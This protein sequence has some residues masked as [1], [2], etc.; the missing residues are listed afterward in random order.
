MYFRNM[1]KDVI[2]RSPFHMSVYTVLYDM[3]CG[4]SGYMWQDGKIVNRYS[5]DHST[6]DNYWETLSTQFPDDLSSKAMIIRRKFIIDNLDALLDDHNIRDPFLGGASPKMPSYMHPNVVSY[7]YANIF[8][9]PENIDDEHKDYILRFVGYW[10]H[11]LR[12]EY[13]VRGNPDHEMD[14]AHWPEHAKVLIR[15]LN[16][17]YNQVLGQEEIDRRKRHLDKLI[18]E[19]LDEEK[20]NG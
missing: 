4:L 15:R 11:L 9:I 12:V 6:Y 13:G 14:I 18:Q 1:I 10:Q 8:N 17:I 20:G 7:E 2:I 3:F 19:I 16:Q 5:D